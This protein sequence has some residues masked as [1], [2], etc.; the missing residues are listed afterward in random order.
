M[1]GE[2]PQLFDVNEVYDPLTDSWTTA[3]PMPIPRH[4]IAAVALDDRVLCP[5]GGTVQGLQPT[6]AADSFVP[7]MPG[8]PTA[9]GWGVAA[10]ALMLAG[11]ATVVLARR[12][13]REAAA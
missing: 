4:G 7:Q 1:G 5:A 12:R 11:A 6:T 9:S 2:V 8:V 13:P 3:L 10:L